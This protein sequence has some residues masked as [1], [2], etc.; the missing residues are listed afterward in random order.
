MSRNFPPVSPRPAAGAAG[1]GDADNSVIRCAIS[2]AFQAWMAQCGGSLAV[3]TYQAG[4]VALIGFDDRPGARQ[5]TLL[6]RQFD[7]PLGLAVRGAGAGMRLAL[8]TRNDVVLLADAPLL[9]RDYLEGQPGRYDA[10]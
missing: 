5:V 8:A 7:K 9:A 1:P 4:K 10:L 6:M 3:T 2:D